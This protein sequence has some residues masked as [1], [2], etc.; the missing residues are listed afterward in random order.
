M[1][2]TS[3]SVAFALALIAML[4]ACNSGGVTGSIAAADPPV[5]CTFLG[6]INGC[7]DNLPVNCT[8]AVPP[9]GASLGALHYNPEGGYFTKGTDPVEITMYFGP[10]SQDVEITIDIYD[11]TDFKAGGFI[12]VG[13]AAPDA[14]LLTVTDIIGDI[15]YVTDVTVW[16]E[17]LNIVSTTQANPGQWK[18]GDTISGS[19]SVI[20][21][22]LLGGVDYYNVWVEFTDLPY[23][24][25]PPV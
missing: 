16:P 18:N 9:F 21:D 5:L 19:F 1:R 20:T 14:T 3:L 6:V 13:G 8:V 25:E 10:G 12:D 24:V 7:V 17:A 11:T 15:S 2:K 22:G 4:G 23:C